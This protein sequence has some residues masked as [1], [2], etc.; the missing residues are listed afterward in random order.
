[1]VSA[2]HFQV[3]WSRASIRTRSIAVV[4]RYSDDTIL[5]PGADSVNAGRRMEVTGMDT[6]VA[7]PQ[8]GTAFT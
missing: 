6:D 5:R 1:M 2:A 8:R 7:L 4:E 3:S